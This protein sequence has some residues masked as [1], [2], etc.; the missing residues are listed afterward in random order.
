MKLDTGQ[1]KLLC[2]D[3][4]V[5][6]SGGASDSVSLSVSSCSLSWWMGTRGTLTVVDVPVVMLS[7]ALCCS[8]RLHLDAG[9]FLRACIWQAFLVVLVRQSTVLF[10]V[11]HTLFRHV[12]AR[13]V[14][15]WK[16]GRL[17]FLRN[18]WLHSGSMFMFSLGETF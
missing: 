13:A 16:S 1:W 4:V 12:C 2:T 10:E 14:R 9:L 8:R 3:I 6:H 7:V 5:D 11:F 17:L 18:T 15:T